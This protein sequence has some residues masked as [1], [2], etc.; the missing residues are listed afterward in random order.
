[1]LFSNR[2]RHSLSIPAHD[3]DGKPTSIASLIHYLCQNV[4]KDPRTEL[5]VLDNHMY[6]CL[7]RRAF[8]AGYSH[9]PRQQYQSS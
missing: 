6:V 5:F 8:C 7:N 3:K 4:M 9:S 2:R 1:M